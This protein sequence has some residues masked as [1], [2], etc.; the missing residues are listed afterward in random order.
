MPKPRI[1][2]NGRFTGAR[3]PTGTQTVA[4]YLFD[5][6]IRRN[7]DF[8]IVIFAD[9]RFSGVPAWREV[10][11]TTVVETPVQDWAR[12]RAQAWEQFVFP[13]L[14]G[15]H[16]C[17]IAHHPI[18]TSPAWHNGCKTVVTLHDLNFYLHPEWVKPAFRAVYQ[19]CA[20]PGFH[21]ADRLVTIS[22]Y[23]REQA[24]RVLR[25]RPER[26]G[27]IYNGAK[28][29]VLDGAPIGRG[30]PY[31]LCVGALAPHKNLIRTIE[32]YLKVRAEVP[33]LELRVVGRAQVNH[34][35]DANL[36]RLLASPGVRM[37][38]YLSEADLARAYAGA[39]VYCYPSLEEGFGLPLLEAMS[40]GTPV[41]TSNL[42]CLPEIAGPNAFLVDPYAVDSIADGIRRAL[43]LAPEE[44]ARIAA[45]GKAWAARFTW[46]A[47][48]DAYLKLYGEMLR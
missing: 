22:H 36:Q 45:E 29:M 15:R 2:L 7:R 19:L 41:L 20:V 27:M 24:E 42:S 46:E 43:R 38:G 8:D 26:M 4:Y 10:P 39:E 44:R 25:I 14:C 47:A 37:T 35:A 32:A 21:R 9:S 33:D 30:A 1:A 34:A 11:G 16:R 6:I 31:L 13:L 5:Q 48:A 28:P 12:S 18:T 23:I 17:A 40:V 3:Q